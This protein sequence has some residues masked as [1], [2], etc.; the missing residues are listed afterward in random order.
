M[1]KKWVRRLDTNVSSHCYPWPTQVTSWISLRLK[2]YQFDTK[3]INFLSG[4]KPCQNPNGTKPFQIFSWAIYPAN[5]NE[6]KFQILSNDKFF[7][8][9]PQVVTNPTTKPSLLFQPR[10]PLPANNPDH[11]II[12]ACK[13][14]RP[15]H[16]HCLQTTHFPCSPTHRTPDL[17]PSLPPDLKSSQMEPMQSMV[18]WSCIENTS[19]RRRR[20]RRS[21]SRR[22]RIGSI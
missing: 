7:Q 2:M 11:L 14:P 3:V 19:Q 20:C 1:L 13:Q 6:I 21:W 10:P 5:F 16:N 18:K 8:G 22:R 12:A 15:P 4:T 9:N 17:K